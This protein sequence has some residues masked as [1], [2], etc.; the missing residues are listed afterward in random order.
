MILIGLFLIYCMSKLIRNAS[1]R[2]KKKKEILNWEGR[3]AEEKAAIDAWYRSYDIEAGKR[4]Q[5]IQNNQ[6]AIRHNQKRIGQFMAYIERKAE[7][8]QFFH[9]EECKAANIEVPDNQVF[10]QQRRSIMGS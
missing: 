4:R 7:I 10:A 3:R 2:S 8:Q 5:D 6:N 1:N 9:Q